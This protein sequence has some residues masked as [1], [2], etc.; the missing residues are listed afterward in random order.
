MTQDSADGLYTSTLDGMVTGLSLITTAEY[1]AANEDTCAPDGIMN[2][3]TLR[4]YDQYSATFP[5]AEART[6]RSAS[7]DRYM[8]AKDSESMGLVSV[9]SLV[10]AKPG[11]VASK[12]SGYFSLTSADPTL[13]IELSE[14][15]SPGVVSIMDIYYDSSFSTFTNY[16]VAVVDTSEAAD[17][18][19]LAECSGTP[20]PLGA[21]FIC[22]YTG[23]V[24]TLGI[25]IYHADGDAEAFGQVTL[26]ILSVAVHP[27]DFSALTEDEC[28]TNI[29]L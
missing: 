11:R 15:L 12:T 3:Y 8:V 27:K 21:D 10:R 9:S 23:A 2:F 28:Y 22:D 19:V 6:T 29:E 14:G 13:Y 4:F 20:G 7:G 18:F 16:G 24:E 25:I 1:V 5:F 17:P 26:N